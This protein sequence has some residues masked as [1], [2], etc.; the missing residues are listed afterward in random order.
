MLPATMSWL[1]ALTVWPDPAGP[2]W[3]TV[4]P[5]ASSTGCAAAKSSAEPPTMIERTAS[6]APCSPPDTGASRTRS[7][8]SLPCAARRLDTSGR[9]EEKSMTRVPSAALAK[10]PSS[11]PRPASTS[12]ESGTI[13]ATTSAP[14]PAS[15]TDAAARG[16]ELV[17]LGLAAVVADDVEVGLD[18][19][20][21]HR[22]AHDAEAD[23]GDSGHDLLPCGVWGAQAVAARRSRGNQAKLSVVVVVG[24]YAVPTQPVERA[25]AIVVR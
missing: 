19:V 21:G 10:T 4:R 20:G 16:Y 2:T 24:L 15:A 14:L 7:P 5:T 11:P 18:E 23:E 17:D 8:A 12:G 1:E 25:P 9:I 6:M 22:P 3:T 13:V